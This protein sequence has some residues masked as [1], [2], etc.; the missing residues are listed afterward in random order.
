MDY[1][2]YLKLAYVG[3]VALFYI[4]FLIAIVGNYIYV[5]KLG[6]GLIIMNANFAVSRSS[7]YSDIKYYYEKEIYRKIGISVSDITFPLVMCA[8]GIGVFVIATI[9]G[10]KKDKKPDM[11]KKNIVADCD[12]FAEKIKEM[13][14]SGVNVVYDII[15][16]RNHKYKYTSLIFFNATYKEACLYCETLDGKRRSFRELSKSIIILCIIAAVDYGIIYF[17]F[18]NDNY[19]ELLELVKGLL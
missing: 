18:K 13:R 12:G 10:I 2:N 15:Y 17:R 9:V 6:F 3:V 16:D 8:V 19:I 5:T 14:K 7:I 4:G 1:I 11:R